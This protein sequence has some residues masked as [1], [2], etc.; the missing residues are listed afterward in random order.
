MNLGQ[1]KLPGGYY[2]KHNASLDLGL[3]IGR[4]LPAKGKQ[5]ESL[6]A[7]VWVGQDDQNKQKYEV[8]DED[9]SAG[10]VLSD[11]LAEEKRE[12]RKRA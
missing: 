4:N 3:R 6:L 5:E 7:A 12:D 2:C 1:N 10:V 11:A 9:G 8:W